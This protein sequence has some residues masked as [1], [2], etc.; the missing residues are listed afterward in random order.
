MPVDPTPELQS[1]RAHKSALPPAPPCRRATI[2]SSRGRSAGHTIRLALPLATSK[3]KEEARKRR[4]HGIAVGAPRIC[5]DI[6][7]AEKRVSAGQPPRRQEY[8]APRR[9]ARTEDQQETRG[10]R[11]SAADL[12]PGCDF[13]SHET[14][15][16]DI[17][18]RRNLPHLCSCTRRPID[19]AGTTRPALNSAHPGRQSRKP[20][21][22][23]PEREANGRM[24]GRACSSAMSAPN[25]VVLS[26]N[27]SRARGT[28]NGRRILPY[29]RGNSIGVA[30]WGNGDALRRP[31]LG[32]GFCLTR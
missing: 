30:G 12:S 27:P 3:E 18:S 15:V 10:R 11:P 19:P 26:C 28:A 31:A 17:A 29:S 14:Q 6:G 5:E 16:T 4:R 32:K 20:R 9:E 7:S 2:R 22:R 23:S 24:M 25:Q 1:D 8:G 13:R 21:T